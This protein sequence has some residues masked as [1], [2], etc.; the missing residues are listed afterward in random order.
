MVEKKWFF[1]PLE[2]FIFRESRNEI[3]FLSSSFYHKSLM[4]WSKNVGLCKYLFFLLFI[5]SVRL[6]CKIYHSTLLKV[7]VKVDNCNKISQFF[8]SD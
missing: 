8:P 4:D 6:M 5:F 3:F 2:R 1:F 7:V